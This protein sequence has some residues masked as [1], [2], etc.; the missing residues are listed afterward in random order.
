MNN[1]PDLM[2]QTFDLLSMPAFIIDAHL[3]IVSF[4]DTAGSLFHYTHAD[5]ADL[6]IADIA[7]RAPEFSDELHVAPPRLVLEPLDGRAPG[8]PYQEVLCRK[9]DGELFSAGLSLLPYRDTL[10][11]VVIQD[12][13]DKRKLQQRASQ[14]T[15]ELSIFNAFAKILTS[16][17]DIH[18]IMHQT[19]DM[20]IGIMGA[21]KAWIHLTGEA[22]GELSL[23]VQRNFSKAMYGQLKQLK[24][25][26]GLSGKVFT[27]RRPLLVKK[28]SEDPRVSFREEGMES[29]A[30]APIMSSRGLILGV[31]TVSNRSASYF[32]S[33]D[34]Q[35]LTVVGN[36]L[37]VA[38]ENAR[39]ISQLRDKMRQIELI[40]ELSGIINSSLSIGTVFRIM[41]SEIRKLIEYDRASLLFFNEKEKNLTIFALDTDMKTILKK[42]VKAPLAGTSAG[43]VIQNNQP[44]IN[45][46]LLSETEFSLDKKLMSE[47]IR[48]TISIPLYR[49]K[50]LGVFN[51]DS[52]TPRKYSEKDLEILLPVAKHIS[53]ALENAILFEEISKEKK[54]W[55][56]TF[57]AIAD[58]VWIEDGVQNV[59]RANKTLLV[60]TGFSVVGITGKSCGEIL[61]KIGISTDRCLCSDTIRTKKPSYLELRGTGGSLFYFWAY[62]LN[63]EEG[64]LYAIVHYLKDVTSQKRLEQ[65]L[66]RA[67]KMAS[68]GTLVA[69]IA[70]EINNPLGIIAG[71]SEAL[72]DRSK[73][74]ALLGMEDFS[75]FPEYLQTIHNEIFR[76]KDILRSLLE[77]SRPHGG[78]FR[79]LDINELIKEVILLVNHKAARLKHNIRLDLNR[80]LP[81]IYADAG[82][83]RQLFMNIIINSMYFTPEGGSITITTEMDPGNEE[84]HVLSRFPD[85]IKVAIN[86]TGAGI[87]ADIIDKIFDPF[88]TTRPVGEGT[89]LGLAIC[90]KIVE[91]HSGAIDVE[92]VPGKGTT[93]I[94]RI[95]ARE[96]DDKDSCS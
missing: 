81:K 96:N 73:E 76:C 50:M 45:H 91:K 40:N 67:D 3:K 57:D 51:L 15:K 65:Q 56:R 17:R 85:I 64:R 88:F 39:L 4:N 84:G 24:P 80:Y 60:K 83:L 29:I 95:P 52:T 22:K 68:L 43:W 27:S 37:G 16:N 94:I 55:E 48:S 47:G 25:G 79:E 20:L 35:L 26:Q 44:R 62:P 5:T 1:K 13:S 93:F 14:R 54:E 2:L 59:V 87:P 41:V 72:L 9:K 70:H 12:I 69:G 92:S 10:R 8:S 86:D 38:L 66:I 77:F 78:T 23:A 7:C 49:D 34:I 90:H 11:L 21:D 74:S 46:D 28:S 82:S 42:G 63:D 30:G 58:M 61:E 71:F 53:I 18:K 31:L 75:D 19:V 6:K 89:G 32:T 33:M 36:Q